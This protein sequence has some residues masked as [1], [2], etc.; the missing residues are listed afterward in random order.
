MPHSDPYVVHDTPGRVGMMPRPARDVT[1]AEDLHLL[2]S[3]HGVDVVVCAL[4]DDELELLG[5]LGEADAVRR[6]GMRFEHFP[7]GDH[8]V[9]E[10]APYQALTAR[11]AAEVTA[12]AYVVAHCW[13]GIGRSGLIAGGVLIQLG[14]SARQAMDR[15]VER[16]GYP[17]ETPSQCDMLVRLAETVASGR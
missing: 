7:V 14:L 16:R 6:A 10:F 4:P 15:L 12:G 1:L 8:D 17:P 11:L 13:A 2:R 3:V 5:L 9:P